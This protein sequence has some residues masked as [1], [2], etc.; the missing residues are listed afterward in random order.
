MPNGRVTFN[1]KGRWDWSDSGCDIDKD[2][3]EQEE[4]FVGDVYYPSDSGYDTPMYDHQIT[5]R[6]SKPEELV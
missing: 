5:E 1:K 2:E 3:L 4:W 6:L